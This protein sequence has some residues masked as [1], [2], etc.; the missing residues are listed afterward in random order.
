MK[1]NTTPVILLV[2]NGSARADATLQLRQLAQGLSLKADTMVH[3]VSLQHADSIPAEELAGEPAHTFVPFMR[4]ALE[5][6]QRRFI[7]LPLFFGNSRA[8]TSY[9]PAEVKALQAEFGDFSVDI[10]GV[11][12]PLPEGEPLLSAIIYEHII[13]TADQYEL[14]LKNIVLVDHGSP[15]PRVT[16]V[17]Q[18]VAAAVQT[19]L[20][21]DVV[22]DQAV[23]ERREGSNYDFNGELLEGYLLSKAQSGESSAIVALMFFLAGR[24]AGA[25]GDIV[26]ICE[27][28]TQQYPEFKIIISPLI[29]AHETLLS[30]LY[31]RLQASVF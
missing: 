22:L 2:D 28:V 4:H 18:H 5:Q 29:S 31:T 8:L 24:H 17:R 9:I 13:Q 15:V 11:I 26:Q 27:S 21:E 1:T 7:V 23:M 12:Y 25:G 6:G 14:P 16:A 10:A 19:Q 3:A 30:I 20:P